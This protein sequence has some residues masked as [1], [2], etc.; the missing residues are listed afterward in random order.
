MTVMVCFFNFFFMGKI[1][2]RK[3]ENSIKIKVAL[4]KPALMLHF[5]EILRDFCFF[6]EIKVQVVES[7]NSDI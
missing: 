2:K 4:F 7:N 1:D 5:E 3:E 6:P